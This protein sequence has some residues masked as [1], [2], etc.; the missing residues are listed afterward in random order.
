MYIESYVHLPL[1]H[2]IFSRDFWTY[3]GAGR[4]SS[5]VFLL[6]PY[7]YRYMDALALLYH[8]YVFTR[9]RACF[10]RIELR[11]GAAQEHIRV[12]GGQESF[13]CSMRIF[14]IRRECVMCGMESQRNVN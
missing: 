3:V 14:E 5:R 8:T 9:R 11:I 1:L 13:N 12:C 7:V 6:Y 2:F 10:L 4:D